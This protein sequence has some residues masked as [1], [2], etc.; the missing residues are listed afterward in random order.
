MCDLAQQN[1]HL[2]IEA[3]EMFDNKK[4]LHIAN[5]ILWTLKHFSWS[6]QTTY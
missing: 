4:L 3:K 5:L 1:S 6:E 2:T